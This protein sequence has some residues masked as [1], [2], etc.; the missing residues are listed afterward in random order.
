[1][2]GAPIGESREDQTR[3][4]GPVQLDRRAWLK[5]VLAIAGAGALTGCG[6]QGYVDASALNCRATPTA[7]AKVVRRLPRGEAVSFGETQGEWTK[8]AGEDCWVSTRFLSA[9]RPA[10]GRASKAEARDDL[11]KT[12]P[13]PRK[14]RDGRKSSRKW[15]YR[16]RR[17]KRRRRD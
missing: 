13:S 7:G 9:D 15:W 8:L 4:G 3:R 14:T 6:R 2:P 12:P 16:R 1:M 10:V 11:A 5:R 17:K